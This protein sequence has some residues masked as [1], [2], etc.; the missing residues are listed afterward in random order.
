MV[1]HQWSS[2]PTTTP[3]EESIFTPST[4]TSQICR[5]LAMKDFA[6]LLALTLETIVARC[7][8][9]Q[10]LVVVLFFHRFVSLDYLFI[11]NELFVVAS[12]IERHRYPSLNSSE[13]V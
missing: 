8:V 3:K 9:S 2:S 7:S 12:T 6:C 11:I 13:W 5:V 1:G 10:V 4:S